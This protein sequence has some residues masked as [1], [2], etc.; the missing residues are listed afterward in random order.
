MLKDILNKIN[1]NIVVKPILLGL[2]TFGLY[3]F[4][5]MIGIFLLVDFTFF[6]LVFY[7]LL[8]YH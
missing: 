7:F 8:F 5:P 3:H 6:Y 2:I 4:L 1:Y